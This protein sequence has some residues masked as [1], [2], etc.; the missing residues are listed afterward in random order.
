[1]GV[2]F[3]PKDRETVMVC[4][5]IYDKPRLVGIPG[6]DGIHLGCAVTHER[7]TIS[8]DIAIHHHVPAIKFD[9]LS[10][11]PD[12]DICGQGSADW[13]LLCKA[14]SRVPAGERLTFETF[15]DAGMMAIRFRDFVEMEKSA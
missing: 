11:G 5:H 8:R 14:C 6:K 15:W 13:D 2:T 3:T 12:S 1:M 7:N 4:I 10:D 9:R